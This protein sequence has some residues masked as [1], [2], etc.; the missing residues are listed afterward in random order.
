MRGRSFAGA[1]S[2]THLDVYKRQGQRFQALFPEC[3]SEQE[4]MYAFLSHGE[5][6]V[7]QDYAAFF[8]PQSGKRKKKKEKNA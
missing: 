5:E 3:P 4:R 2:Y 7:K 8:A 6:Q 1:V